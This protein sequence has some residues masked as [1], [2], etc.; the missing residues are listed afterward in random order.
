MLGD[1]SVTCHLPLAD[2][3]CEVGPL[4]LRQAMLARSRAAAGDPP[5]GFS[6][7]EWE[8]VH[9]LA[10]KVRRC[11]TRDGLTAEELLDMADADTAAIS[12]AAEEVALRERRFRRPPPGPA[13]EPGA[14][15][16]GDGL[17]A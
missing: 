5:Q 8:A 12:A 6:R 3:E 15:G 9:V 11:G 13:V 14:G 1:F 2:V 17:D 10:L 7:G 4:T 16:P